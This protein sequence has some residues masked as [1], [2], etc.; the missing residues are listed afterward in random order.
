MKED[1]ILLGKVTN[2][3]TGETF[4]VYKGDLV[5]NPELY[6][7]YEIVDCGVI[8][9]YS[10]TTIKYEGMFKS[11]YRDEVLLG[12]L[13]FSDI[14]FLK[15]QSN[16]MKVFPYLSEQLYNW[17]LYGKGIGLSIDQTFVKLDR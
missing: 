11:I 7:L 3:L 1:K 15:R 17:R 2:N 10:G 8:T 9:S 4:Y 5:Y 14:I 6:R 13:Q 12:K 16:F